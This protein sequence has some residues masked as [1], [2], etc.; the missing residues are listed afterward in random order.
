MANRQKS[1]ARRGGAAKT[2]ELNTVKSDVDTSFRKLN[3]N[4]PFQNGALFEVTFT[5]PN[6]MRKDIAHKLGGAAQGFWLVDQSAPMSVYRF[7]IS[8]TNKKDTHI[9]LS[10]TASGTVKVWVWR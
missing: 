3:E 9:R 10:S 6:D 4:T 5:A 2:P 1:P 7:D 8:N